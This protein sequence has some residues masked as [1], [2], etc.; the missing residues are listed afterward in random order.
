M[1]LMIDL[2]AWLVQLAYLSLHI[3]RKAR[4]LITNKHTHSRNALMKKHKAYTM[5][6]FGNRF[7]D[8]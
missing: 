2:P 6:E 4:P 8:T 3:A 5:D 7:D 1:L